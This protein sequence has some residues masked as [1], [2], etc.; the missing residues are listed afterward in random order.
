MEKSEYSTRFKKIIA[1][2]EQNRE[3]GIEKLREMAVE[4]FSEAEDELGFFLSEDDKNDDEAVF[5]LKKAVG[6]GN[7]EAAWNIAMIHR[8]KR[9]LVTMRYWIDVSASLGHADAAYAITQN[10]D[11]SSLL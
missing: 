2:I 7:G 1:I 11:V 6:R 4:G 3:T 8:M 10:Y 5:W 9:D